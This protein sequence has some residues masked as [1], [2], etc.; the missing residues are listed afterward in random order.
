MTDQIKN[1]VVYYSLDGNTAF[2]A[3]TLAEAIQADL[4]TLQPRKTPAS[5]TILKILWGVK[6]VLF[7]EKPELR[8]FDK[9]PTAYDLIFLGTPVWAGGYAPALRT[10]FSTTSLQQKHVALFCCYRG[11]EGQTF[12][13]M[14]AELADNTLVGSQGFREPLQD[15]E[16]NAQKAHEWAKMIREKIS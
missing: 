5:L 2:I 13:K 3:K 15:A 6:Q 9:D 8:P 14:K 12:D 1:L 11:N 4:L 7:K 10:F 16:V